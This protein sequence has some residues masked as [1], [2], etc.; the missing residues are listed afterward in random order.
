[1]KSK[2][3]IAAILAADPS[4]EAE[5]CVGNCDITDISAMSAYY[6]GCLQVLIHDPALAPY[7]DIIGGKYVG[8]G[9]K[10]QIDI[11]SIQDSIFND[12]N[13]PVTYEG[14]SDSKKEYYEQRIIQSR[15][16]TKQ[17]CDGV[18]QDHFIAYIKNRY[19][20]YPDFDDVLE[21]IA[22]AYYEANLSYLDSLPKLDPVDEEIGGEKYQ[23][24]PSIHTRREYQWNKEV[25]IAIE[26]GKPVLRKN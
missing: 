14:I 3:V 18:N 2:D 7:Y 10:I 11:R 6:D 16:L 25:E 21:E 17:I 5:C 24:H 19:K 23:V 9:I 26:N 15:Q 1:M 4:G 20:E 13:M 12:E 8:S 22:I